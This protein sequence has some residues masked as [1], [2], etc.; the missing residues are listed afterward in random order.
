MEDKFSI[1]VDLQSDIEDYWK[2]SRAVTIDEGAFH[3]FS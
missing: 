3:A 2:E 1:F